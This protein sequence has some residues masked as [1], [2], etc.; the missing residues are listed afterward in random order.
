MRIDNPHARNSAVIVDSGATR[1]RPVI[2][3]RHLIS[4]GL[5]GM[6]FF[7]IASAGGTPAN[8]G[9]APVISDPHA[10]HH[11]GSNSDVRRSE[12]HYAIPNVTL[13][14]DDGK[15]VALPAELDDGR[16]VVLN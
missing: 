11:P 9:D 13:V 5:L 2:G 10:H 15:S 3:A 4:A 16:P 14:R 7:A 6:S 1:M 12:V 8:A